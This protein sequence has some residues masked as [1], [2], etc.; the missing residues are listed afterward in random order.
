MILRSS[1]AHSQL[2]KWI[3]AEQKMQAMALQVAMTNLESHTRLSE[4]CIQLF[5]SKAGK[6]YYK[7]QSLLNSLN[8]DLVI[9]RN[10]KIHST[11]SSILDPIHR[12]KRLLLD[13]VDQSHI[14]IVRDETLQLCNYL[15][16]HIKSLKEEMKAL[17]LEENKFREQVMITS[18]LQSLDGTLADIQSLEQEIQKK[19]S[20]TERDFRR[21]C[22]K[23]AKLL[24]IPVSSLLETLPASFMMNSTLS[25]LPSSPVSPTI[26]LTNKRK[27]DI[28]A[29]DK[30]KAFESMYHLAEFHVND[31]LPKMAQ[32]EHAIRQKTFDLIMSKRKAIKS[33]ITNMAVVSKFE[34]HVG[35][36]QPDVDEHMQYLNEFKEKYNGQD[37]ESLRGILFA[38][39]RL[40]YIRK[41]KDIK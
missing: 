39:V 3:V 13:F 5:V 2:A 36:V 37:L 31:Y 8:D 4:A 12:H 16:K 30:K 17:K 25:S 1:A 29:S 22:D 38:Y 15:A 19:R 20:R 27:D 7:Q 10:V 34:Q 24:D 18:N 11:I 21:V 28:K 40:F 35:R 23:I 26:P 33:F 9:L 6:E 14:S 41:G 32:Y